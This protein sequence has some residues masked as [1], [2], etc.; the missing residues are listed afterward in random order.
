MT[1]IVRIFTH[2]GLITAPVAPG[3]G[4]FSSDSVGLLKQ[5]PE[6]REKLTASTGA[7]VS[8]AAATATGSTRLV[9]VQVQAGKIVH[10]EV[11]PEGRDLVEAGDTSPTITG[12]VVIQFG[13]GW[14]I[15]FKENADG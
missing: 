15:S 13:S 9:F 2:S 4:R 3:S 7:A 6:G 8:S 1:A 10:Y 5:P 11:T 12:E 14:R